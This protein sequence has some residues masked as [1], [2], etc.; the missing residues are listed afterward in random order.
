MMKVKTVNAK[1]F[2]VK[3]GLGHDFACN[4]YNGCENGCLYCYAQTMPGPSNRYEP[5]GTYI[6]IKEYPNYNIPKNTGS[7]SLFFS[8][9]TDPYQPIEAT[10]RKTREAI[11]SIYES[12]LDISILTKSS[13]VTRDLDLFR[14]MKSVKIGFSIALDDDYA[15]IFEPRASKPSERIK[16]LKALHRAGIKTYVFISPII[17]Y[18]TDV[19]KIIDEVKDDVDYLMFDTLNLKDPANKRR[20]FR[21]IETLKPDR[22]NDYHNIFDLRSSSYYEDLKAQIID[23]IEELKIPCHYLY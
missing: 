1:S 16:A 14:Q 15:N 21:V 8:S 18:I 2:L 10:A 17:P 4:P 12:L 19:F 9:M 23:Y 6:D 5:W 3:T 13:L 11:E 22:I 7:K 20:I